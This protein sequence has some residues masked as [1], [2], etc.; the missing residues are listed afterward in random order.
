MLRNIYNLRPWKQND[1]EKEKI[2]RSMSFTQVGNDLNEDKFYFLQ[3][4]GMGHSEDAVK[5]A[6]VIAY[7]F[8]QYSLKHGLE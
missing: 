4:K 2:D 8:T 3:H 1:Y 6:T 7:E 5:Y